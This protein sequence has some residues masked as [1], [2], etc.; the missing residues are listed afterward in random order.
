[1]IPIDLERGLVVGGLISGGLVFFYAL[2]W[3]GERR[4]KKAGEIISQEDPE[5]LNNMHV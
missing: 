1:M 4:I 3:I 5:E 2:S